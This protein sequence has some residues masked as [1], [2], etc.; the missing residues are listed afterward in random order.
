MANWGSKTGGQ[1]FDEATIEA[2]W[3]KGATEI[4]DSEL[5][6]LMSALPQSRWKR[7]KEEG[8]LVLGIQYRLRG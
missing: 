1:G 3:K 8:S 4:G 5:I 2:E 6:W 7:P